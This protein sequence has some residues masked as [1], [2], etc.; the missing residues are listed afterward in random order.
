MTVNINGESIALISEDNPFDLFARHAKATPNAPAVLSLEGDCSYGDLQAHATNVCEAL[1]RLGL[2]PE[3]P[4]G[5][6]M[7][8]SPALIGVL[9][10]IWKA[11]GAWAPF[12][13]QDPPQRIGRMLQSAGC[14]LVLG[15]DDLLHPVSR[16]LADT[17]PGEPAM[18]FVDAKTMGATHTW[19]AETSAPCAPGGARLA[20][21]LFTSGSTGQPK[22]VEIEHR[23]VLNLLLAARDLIAFTAADRYL[24]TATV[25]FDISVAELFLPLITGGSLLLRD[26]V[27]LLDPHRLARDIRR[28]RVT[29]FQAGPSLWSLVLSQVPDFPRL[30]VAISTGEAI[31]PD[32]A[33]RLAGIGEQ[34]WNLYGP[35]ETTVWAT[36]HR[37]TAEGVTREVASPMSAPIGR[38]MAHMW[39]RIVDEQG[40]QVPDGVHGELCIGGLGVARGYRGNEALTQQR[41]VAMGT[42]GSRYYRTGDVVVRDAEGVLHYFG[43]NDDQLKIRG[44]RIEPSEV[45][46]EILR[47]PKVSQAAATWFERQ[48]GTRSIIAAVVTKAGMSCTPEELARGMAAH[49]PAQ[50]IP[51]RF[52]FVTTLALT[53]SGKVDRN[54]IRQAAAAAAASETQPSAT[55]PLTKTEKVVS[56][57]WQAVLRVA[58]VAPHDHFF[59]IG[60]DSLAAVQ[61]LVEVEKRF[62]IKLPVQLPFEAPTLEQLAARLERAMVEPN[63]DL[64]NTDFV[65]P[66]VPAGVGT[67]L[68][69]SNVDLTLARKGLWQVACPLFA[70]TM[71]A[72]GSGFVKAESLS[73]LAAAQIESLRRVQPAGPYRI[74]GYSIGG[75]IAFEMAQQLKRNGDV[76]ELLFLLDPLEPFQSAGAPQRQP[77]AVLPWD[78]LPRRISR[79][80][81]AIAD[82]PQKLGLQAW[83]M[84]LVPPFGAMPIVQWAIYGLVHL[85]GKYPNRFTALLL[86]KERGPAFVYAARRM[87]ASYVAQAYEGRTLAVFLNNEPGLETWSSLLGS[88][89]HI[90]T[91]SADHHSLFQDAAMTRWMPSL[92]QA[93]D[94]CSKQ[95]SQPPRSSHL[96]PAG[97]ASF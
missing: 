28:H 96:A 60:G 87:A 75:L 84:S 40:A 90:S 23:S 64:L 85:Y 71:W 68:F 15:D 29:V 76:V 59:S 45:E 57:I 33:R 7:H 12:D 10:G 20:Y 48:E 97:A 86:P 69:F 82:G 73:A 93:V 16:S 31:S 13:P 72:R 65:F 8:R 95:Q 58:S 92:A 6:L 61:M 62:N 77:A 83:A 43:R 21:L 91:I 49:M 11:G 94:A 25:A 3:Q 53:P 2:N 63:V 4:V 35:T 26:R 38:P 66:I 70:V 56:E 5:V 9:L 32:L 41:F 74:A 37:L 36:A 80:L 55:R 67:P 81:K 88:Q 34:V 39:A 44:F 27:L 24:A 46:S 50:M 42:D 78:P 89:A 14:R 30:R 18:A 51:A 52:V 17:A 54:A 79:R 1:L 47:N 19:G 22:A